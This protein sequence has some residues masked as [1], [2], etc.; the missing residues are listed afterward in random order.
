MSEGPNRESWDGVS[1]ALAINPN[2]SWANAVKGALLLHS[3]QPAQ[4]REALLTALRLDP[5][6]P[7]SVMPLT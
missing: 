6:G 1:I 3:G 7:I 4:A 5:H 2:S